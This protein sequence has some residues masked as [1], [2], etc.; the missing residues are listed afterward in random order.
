MFPERHPFFF[1]ERLVFSLQR[2]RTLPGVP[3]RDR[4][5]LA[6]ALAAA[7][8]CIAVPAGASINIY[9]V[10]IFIDFPNRSAPI[11]ITNT[12][13]S[14]V[15]VWLGF[16]YGYPVAFDTGQVVF[17]WSDT[18]ASAPTNGAPWMRAVPERI[19]LQPGISQ[20]VRVI[21]SPPSILPDG[22]Y[23]ARGV[24]SYKRTKRLSGAKEKGIVTSLVT[25][26]VVPVHYRKGVLSSG[27]VMHDLAAKVDGQRLDVSFSLSRTG[28][29]AYW[30]SAQVN[31]INGTGKI[32]DTRRHPVV[33]Y[34]QL[35]YKN[36]VDLEA[37]P[38]GPYTL[39]VMLDTK[40]PAI[41]KNI[42]INSTPVSETVKF[43]IP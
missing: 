23:W 38:P 19:V 1:R 41:K 28:N 9:P 42:R 21:V 29:A 10:Q 39:S 12:S 14:P 18:I 24:V 2:V 5:P 13:D 26:L 35:T 31:L 3:R 30:G 4:H 40:H 37:L 25:D 7:L 33:V 22:E 8:L 43:T 32:V 20:T 17:N 6:I 27:I 11:A 36:L 34:K 16:R 15:E